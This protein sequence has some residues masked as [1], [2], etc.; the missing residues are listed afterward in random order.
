[1]K[2]RT[3]DIL[4]DSDRLNTILD[5]LLES[6]WLGPVDSVY[7]VSSAYGFHRG[8][9]FW[10]H[11]REIKSLRAVTS[12]LHEQL[13]ERMTVVLFKREEALALAHEL[14]PASTSSSKH[15]RNSMSTPPVRERRERTWKDCQGQKLSF[16]FNELGPMQQQRQQQQCMDTRTTNPEVFD[17]NGSSEIG[18]EKVK[19]ISPVMETSSRLRKRHSA[20]I[21]ISPPQGQHHF[22]KKPPVTDHEPGYLAATISSSS[23]HRPP[24]SAVPHDQV[25]NSSNFLRYS[26]SPSPSGIYSTNYHDRSKYPA[27]YSSSNN[28]INKGAYNVTSSGHNSASKLAA[29]PRS[30]KKMKS[31]SILRERIYVNRRALSPPPMPLPPLNL[32]FLSSDI[33]YSSR[34]YSLYG[35]ATSMTTTTAVTVST[36]RSSMIS[37]HYQYYRS[38]SQSSVQESP[39]SSEK[40]LGMIASYGY[41]KDAF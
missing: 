9:A 21:L 30:L 32:E 40:N 37:P 23:R 18:H 7:S 39:V 31:A 2:T 29:F 19:A 36:R 1:M 25:E 41:P 12:F 15:A 16:D 3:I 38:F 24:R 8:R 28:N 11:K 10:G 26:L 34:R 22:V 33:D 14:L 4:C 17:I 6:L 13:N 5:T 35:V 27:N 20:K